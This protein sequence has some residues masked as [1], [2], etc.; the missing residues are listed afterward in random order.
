MVRR[1]RRA[2]ARR[3]LALALATIALAACESN[4]TVPVPAGS[5]S[6]GGAG[7]DVGGYS[8]EYTCEGSG[9][10]TVLLDAGL[11]ASGD[12]EFGDFLSRVAELGV[13][14]CTYDRAGLG[15]SDARPQGDGLPTA[16]TQAD[17]LHAL[18]EGSDIETPLVYV[19]HSY[20]GL[21]ARVFADRYP[22]DVAGFVFED[23]STAWEIDLWPRW[24]DSPWI[25]GTKVD[26][27]ATEREVLDAAPLGDT[28]SIVVS[29]SRYDEEGIPRWAG[30]IFARQQAKLATL[31][32]DVLHV[33]AD[34]SG[35]WI[36][37]DR[38]D[39]L[40]QAID[41]VAQA[42]RDGGT[43]PSCEDA[44]EMRRVTCL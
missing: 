27:A 28:P 44:F 6:T 4:P 13:R 42:V 1:P 29:Q 11:G 40:L 34:G 14:A 43:M 10:P 23:V 35:H 19:P 12:D 17:E 36:H 37:R 26:I 32:D 9:S 31:G 38:P 21:V 20:A 24:D 3:N 8:L 16:A 2:S 25:D 22:E 39:V 5:G 18:L 41:I 30:P 33:R 15:S 7:V